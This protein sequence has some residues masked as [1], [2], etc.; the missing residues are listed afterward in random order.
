MTIKSQSMVS[1]FTQGFSP[2]KSV[3]KD[4][5]RGIRKG[6]KLN[7]ITFDTKN[8]VGDTVIYVVNN[9]VD[10]FTLK[11][12]FNIIEWETQ[13]CDFQEYTFD[14]S[15]CSQKHLK[16]FIDSYQFLQKKEDVYIS[17]YSDRTEMTVKY[18]PDRKDCIMLTFR[19]LALPK[20]E[21]KDLYKSLK[22]KT[23]A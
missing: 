2:I 23:T 14:C 21:Y 7:G 13:Y 16:W 3:Q 17:S 4:I 5:E 6:R 1:L 11:F 20:K 22:K 12:T 9:G 18:K 15:P 8:K 10:N 19:H